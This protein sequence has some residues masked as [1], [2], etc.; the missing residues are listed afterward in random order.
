MK[1]GIV[2]V[3]GGKNYGSYW[4]ARVLHDYLTSLG[5]DVY[6]YDSKSRSIKPLLR[7]SI[8]ALLKLDLKKSAFFLRMYRFFKHN[9]DEVQTVHSK[10]EL[11]DFDLMVFG[12]DEIWNVARSDMASQEEFRGIGFN[13]IKKIAYAPSINYAT[14]DEL[15]K[16]GFDN[17]LKSFSAVSVRDSYSVSEIRKIYSGEIH[18]VLDPTF[19]FDKQ[20][21]SKIPFTPIKER[22]IGVY[23]FDVSDD[24]YQKMRSL[25][26]TL[27]LKLVRIGTYDA[28][29][30]EC[31][32]SKNAFCYFLD[33]EYII[34]NTFHGT[35]FSINFSKQFI[36]LDYHHVAKIRNLL[37]KFN[38]S[39]REMS[40]LSAQDIYKRLIESPIDWIAT[41]KMVDDSREYS[42]NFLANA[43]GT[44]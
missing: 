31:V 12:S 36:I 38:L 34:S 39:S 25:A 9:L 15:H 10:K 16:Y 27:G 43:V 11:N 29:F 26:N 19:L 18:E 30:D 32:I 1:I 4:Q 21:Y 33:A 24:A 3:H 40:D 6:F 17:A 14:A 41:S 22:Y 37:A 44:K 13:N 35:A 7:N 42:R 23:Y 5:H 28:R 2:T 20:Y 8:K